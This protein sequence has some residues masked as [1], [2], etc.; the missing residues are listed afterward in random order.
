MARK[1]LYLITTFR[2]RERKRLY[3]I[4]TLRQK[5]RNWLFQIRLTPAYKNKWIKNLQAEIRHFRHLLYKNL[6]ITI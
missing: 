6:T 5:A 2:Q 4:T 3:E 1:W